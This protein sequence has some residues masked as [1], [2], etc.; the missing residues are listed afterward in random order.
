MLVAEVECF[1]RDL[2]NTLDK[3]HINCG[4]LYCI[5]KSTLKSCPFSRAQEILNQ[6]HSQLKNQ[7]C[8]PPAILE[9]IFCDCSRPPQTN[10]YMHTTWAV[11]SIFNTH[12]P[13]ESQACSG[14]FLKDFGV[15]CNK[16]CTSCRNLKSRLEIIE[17][18]RILFA[19]TM[20][21]TLQ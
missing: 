14:L 10:V 18:Q 16:A 6:R 8:T 4:N 2:F 7:A 3:G 17:A 11:K 1:L 21:S 5:L 12:P 13:C 9:N 20:I 19:Y 15:K